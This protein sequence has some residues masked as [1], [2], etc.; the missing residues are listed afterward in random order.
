MIPSFAAGLLA[1][2]RP[3]VQVAFGAAGAGAT[4]TSGGAL[5]VAYPSGIVAGMLLVLHASAVDGTGASVS[6]PAGW[7][8]LKS[9]AVGTFRAFSFFK[10]ADGTE[11]GSLSVSYIGSVYAQARMFRFV[12]GSVVE[13]QAS[14]QAAGSATALTNPSITTT[15][16]LELAVLLESYTGAATTVS[17]ASGGFA[18]PVAVYTSSS[19]GLAIQTQA[20][21]SP[22]TLSGGAATLGA[23]RTNRCN[24]AF[25]IMP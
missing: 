5:S 7:S 15:Q 6:A 9:T 1:S 22:A 21:A 23:A 2:A 24:I 18:Q 17:D 4:A 3:S 10:I 20:V 19:G 13:S 11:S 16:T 25:A 8:T 12:G 14:G